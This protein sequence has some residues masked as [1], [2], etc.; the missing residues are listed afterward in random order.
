MPN[1]SIEQLRRI[2]ALSDLPDDHLRW[3]AERV[4]YAEYED[5]VLVATK[6]EPADWMWFMLEGRIDFY[7]D[8][9]GQ[10]VYYYNFQN[11]SVT[12]GAGGLLPYSRMKSS[13]GYAYAVGKVWVDARHENGWNRF[14][15]ATRATHPVAKEKAAITAQVK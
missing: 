14:M 8:M 13:P 9:N 2:I 12:G 1:E 15:V 3:L 7:M 6:G 4:E 11:D 5:G 10:Q